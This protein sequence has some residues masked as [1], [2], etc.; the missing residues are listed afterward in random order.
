MKAHIRLHLPPLAEFGPQSRLPFERVARD[1]GV[2]QSGCLSV[3]ELAQASGRHPV[4][5]ILHAQDAV[6]ARVAVPPLSRA[7]L[8]AAVPGIVEGMALSPLAS[9][10]VGHGPREADGQ[11]VIAWAERAALQDAAA[12]L[13]A[14]G[15]RLSAVLPQAVLAAVDDD[16][17]NDVGPAPALPAWS[18]P[19]APSASARSGY[20]GLA[21]LAWLGLALAVWTLVLNLEARRLAAEAQQL[22]RALRAQV[23]AAF[24]QVS[25]VIA[26]LAQARAQRDALRRDRAAGAQDF[27]PLAQ[28]VAHAVP[29]LAGQVDA[30]EYRDGVLSLR[31]RSADWAGPAAAPAGVGAEWQLLRDPADPAL[32][33]VRPAGT[34][35]DAS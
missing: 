17:A 1:G 13:G 10:A 35:K 33:H 11:V 23:Q 34:G 26:P 27:L 25:V 2:A 18:L 15:L 14:A 30:L 9:L 28:A 12:R 6:V 3:A 32:W 5:A 31:L 22:E 4:I 8:D 24:P 7:R 29:A 19:W 21:A 16:V 20:G